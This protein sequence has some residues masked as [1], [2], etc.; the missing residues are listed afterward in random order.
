MRRAAPGPQLAA[1]RVRVDAAR[2]IAKLREYQLADRNAWVLEAIRAAVAARATRVE[3]RA[4]ANDV[5]LTWHGEPWSDDV[6]PR[7]FDELV[8]PEAASD[9]QH[10]RLLAAAINSALGLEPAYVDVVAFGDATATR[11]RY[12]PEILAAPASELGDS[13]L[14]ELASESISL[15]AGARPGMLVHLRRR[16]ADWRVFSDAPELALAQ[17]ACRDLAVPLHVE[18]RVLHR[19]D[20]HEVVR[21]PLGEGL[22]GF[23]AI[24]EAGDARSEPVLEVAEHGVVLATY[25]LDLVAPRQRGVMPVRVYIDAPR[26]PTNASRSQVRR[27]AHPIAAAERRARELVPDLIAQLARLAGEGSERARSSALA[28]LG[29]VAG[30][31]HWH[32][33]VPSLRGPLRQLVQQPL[34][35]NAV[36]EPRALTAYWRAEVHAG[37]RPFDARLAPWLGDVL[38]VPSE[39]ASAQLVERVTI[40][41]R[42]TRRLARWA[43]R[44]LRA[45]DQ[46]YAHGKRE[47]RVLTTG[48]PH[49]RV[50]LG[51]PVERSCIADDVFTGMTG[52]VCIYAEGRAAALA[53]LLDGR[54]LERIELESPLAFD[55]VIDTH[56]ITPADRYR[57]VKRDGAYTR[58]ERAMR[59]GLVRALESHAL[60]RRDP[61]A[62]V[63]DARLFRCAFG[64]L[65]ELGLPVHGPLAVA[66]A[67][68]ATDGRWLSLMDLAS[69]RAIGFALP[70]RGV[71]VPAGRTVLEIDDPDAAVLAPLTGDRLV[72]Y[73]RP[74]GC[75]VGALARSLAMEGG[76]S[77]VIRE[78]TFLAVVT[79]SRVPVLRL[80]HVGVSVE[81]SPYMSQWLPCKIVID[82]D[83][84]V[85]DESWTRVVDDAGLR[86]RDF[87]TWE[88]A[89][90]RAVGR[91]LAGEAPDQLVV[92]GGMQIDGRL[93]RL[94]CEAIVRHDPIEL[95]GAEL[96][97]R[98]RAARV[99]RV[100]GSHE[101]QS[102]AE[103]AQSFPAGIPYLVEPAESIDG[104]AP[105]ICPEHVARAFAKL[106]GLEAIEASATLAEHRRHAVRERN[107]AAHRLRPQ[108][109]RSVPA[110]IHVAL[111]GEIVR[112]VVGAWAHPFEIHVL[113]EQRLLSIVRPVDS[114][115]PLVAAVEIDA[116]RCGDAFDGIPDETRRQIA[117]EVRAAVP[118]LLAA[119][120]ERAPEQLGQPGPARQLLATMPIT[121]PRIRAQLLAAPAF[122]TVQGGRVSLEQAAHPLFAISVAAWQGDWLG[123]EGEPEH[124][125]DAP[126]LFVPD[127]QHELRR[128]VEKLHEG[129]IVDVTEEV[130]R[131]QTRR[132]I[133][134]GLVPRP[135]VRNTPPELKRPLSAFGAAG[136]QLGIGEIA[137][138]EELGSKVMLYEDGNLV[139]TESADVLPGVAVAIQLAEP[140]ALRDPIQRLATELVDQVLASV[141]PDS[142]A[143][144]V[145]RNL[146][147][148]A[149]ARRIAP[150]ALAKLTRWRELAEQIERFG[151][152]WAV[153]E[154]TDATP[155]DE[156][157]RVFFLERSDYELARA[158]GWPMIDAIQELL[159][160]GLARRNRAREPARSLELPS[161]T[162][163]LAEIQLTGDGVT[164]PRGV[165]G[166][167]APVHASARGVWPHRAMHPFDRVDDPC[168]WPT[169]AVVD[170]AR[171][172]PDRTWQG[173]QRNDVWQAVAR[174][175]RTASERA[176]ATIGEVPEDALVSVHVTNRVC[177]D[178]I[179]LKNAPRSMIRGVLWLIG[180][181]RQS[182]AVQVTEHVRVRSF[183]APGELAIGG[184]LLVFSP[185]GLDV[186]L[187]LAQ[188]CKLMHT[189]LVRMLMKRDD[190][191]PDLVAAHVAHAIA[192]RTLRA[193]DARA[194][195]F[196]CFSPRP[197]DARAFKSLLGRDHPV[198]VI[199]PGVDP[200]PDP[201]V[202]ELVDDG[203][204]LARTLIA[205]L[206]SRIR[207]QRQAPRPP[208]AP[209]PA[210][211]AATPPPEPAKP[212]P[213]EPP[214]PLRALVARLRS[215]LGDLGIGGYGWTIVARE[216]P[217]FAFDGEI[218]VAGDN[219]RLRA[220]A[221]ALASNSAFASAGV[222]VVVAHLVTVLNIALSQ[223]TDASEAHALGVLLASP[224]S[225]GRPRSRR[226]S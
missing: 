173:P 55:V 112:G 160:D 180:E 76:G 128:I 75:D 108:S 72:P 114:D 110:D 144:R 122:E 158:N 197:L 9:S 25:P 96:F 37:D 66:P 102:I 105:L 177:A 70:G 95:L 166:V 77:L 14:R 193:T 4:D 47:I 120:A 140:I 171:L 74:Q 54:E 221:A 175:L 170:D 97:D 99:L 64:L 10:V 7:L 59:A 2:A 21:V 116:A 87:T 183:V 204:I 109:A 207:R 141:E 15:P 198:T 154:P 67:Y 48:A 130:T 161:R 157:R 222:D 80:D 22:D 107:L 111:A 103:I 135:E 211:R 20:A 165:V 208:P 27:D 115:L 190:V 33:D 142:L 226:S 225:A 164:S 63:E 100:L 156:N 121:D 62:V 137:L 91:G 168:R 172:A 129:I 41:T 131:L 146:V 86:R 167:L 118:E 169:V 42:G 81:E 82:C 125:L 119:I 88:L 187:A 90:L 143:P 127:E 212:R 133:A 26:M 155:L 57:G 189:K 134:R 179:A 139:R 126:I 124:G 201:D 213:P 104:F 29:A 113:V 65:A 150:G 31:P 17:A 92:P 215:R 36:G 209:E 191:D 24:T 51:V 203:S 163:V 117:L 192:S 224:R 45:R 43:R 194:I 49:V 188:L 182:V 218:E 13:A 50:P 52:E 159:L 8:S 205:A 181:P 210:A 53:I 94:L 69:E 34:V 38:W 147:R 136:T 1:G 73:R 149:L 200:H 216:E 162:G 106:A 185:D 219:P 93:A 85:P 174:D 68:P 138:V 214:H 202:I 184:K 151:D 196:F 178:V 23:V 176:L 217:M 79:P 3:L 101:P 123:P 58:V 39:D 46:F 12:T 195:E 30:G 78:T 220:L 11:V 152:A 71:Y 186:D 61:G 60:V 98:L 206:G 28:L 132:R 223:I 40:D 84:I 32:V 83:A 89:F 56:A 199:K 5:W 35:R 145:Q 153:L 6:L 148:A 18:G 16:L 44:Q 19:D